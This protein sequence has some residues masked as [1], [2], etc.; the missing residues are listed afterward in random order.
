MPLI[1]KILIIAVLI[2]II[3]AVVLRI[4]LNLKRYK[5]MQAHLAQVCTKRVNARLVRFKA[6]GTGK[7]Q[8]WQAVYRYNV[9][10][11]VCEYATMPKP[12]SMAKPKPGSKIIIF[13]NPNYPQEAYNPKDTIIPAKKQREKKS[14]K[15]EG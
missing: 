14:S 15:K 8:K 6:K 11:I 7:R 10:N 12:A 3:G 5:A 13:V 2:I 1:A 4:A 9:K